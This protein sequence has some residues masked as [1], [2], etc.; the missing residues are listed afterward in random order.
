MSI[1]VSNYKEQREVELRLYAP[2][3]EV[4]ELTF[5]PLKI[6]EEPDW[7][8]QWEEWHAYA[9]PLVIYEQ[10]YTILLEDYFA[11][12]YPTKNAFDGTPEPC[13]DFCFDNWLGTDDWK[14]VI[15]EIEKDLDN[16]P[17]DRKTFYT[18]FLNWLK[19]ALQH[20]TIIVVE[21]NQ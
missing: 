12:M 17:A 16:F 18:D 3:S 20:T 8:P 21:G 13:F 4:I 19:E 1:W 7:N 6:S 11:K 9:M 10:D 15:T 14:K 2:K 5:Y